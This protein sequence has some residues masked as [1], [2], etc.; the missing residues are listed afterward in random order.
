MRVANL[1]P[2]IPACNI[3]FIPNLQTKTYVDRFRTYGTG[4][5]I[6]SHAL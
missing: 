2:I 6:G 3:C 4:P 5:Y 1:V